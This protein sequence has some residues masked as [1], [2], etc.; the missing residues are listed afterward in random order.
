MYVYFI[1]DSGLKDCI[2]IG[3]TN[4]LEKRLSTLNTGN[5]S[6]LIIRKYITCDNISYVK[7]ERLLHKYFESNKKINEWFNITINQIN[8]VLKIVN[9]GLFLRSKNIN[10]SIL[11]N[12]YLYNYLKIDTHS[13]NKND[14]L[15][16][17]DDIDIYVDSIGYKNIML[18]NDIVISEAINNT[19]DIK[20]TSNDIIDNI[21]ETDNLV[22]EN[23]T[24]LQLL[25]EYMNQESQQ[26]N[27]C[28]I[29]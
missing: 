12:K 2:K 24:L 16:I 8:S 9:L 19:P 17:A 15:K 21:E 26:N 14:Y 23:K 29:L 11:N 28:I 5:S 4:N 6:K 18:L 10:T 13:D 1:E 20:E 7:M 27:C 3:R 25:S 22:N